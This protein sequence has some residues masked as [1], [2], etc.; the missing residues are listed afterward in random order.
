MKKNYIVLAAILVVIVI[1]ISAGSFIKGKAP[2]GKDAAVPVSVELYEQAKA[3][4]E[5]GAYL[6]ARTIYK[7]LIEKPQDEEIAMNVQSDLTRINMS[8]LF[9]PI[10]TEE[11][12]FYTVKKG[13]TLGKIAREFSTTVELIMKSNNLESDLIRI[14][15]RLKISTAKYSVVV[16]HSQNILTLKSG[17]EVLKTYKVSTGINNST[18]I[19]TFKIVLKEKDPTWYKTGAI[20][21]PGS[22][23]NILGSR[24]M[25]LSIAHYGIH[26][27][28]NSETIGTHVTAGCI[29]MKEPEVQEL[30]AILPIG[31][32]VTIIE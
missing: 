28:N 3:L 26:G 25:G 22:P 1:A 7:E 6:D 18:P 31:T 27:T 5:K 13:D 14:G 17:E 32:E 21:P 15:R 29:R 9:S 4:E 12:T 8:I 16:D 24:W 10:A 19:G 20:I 23:D 2:A 30:Y 11:S